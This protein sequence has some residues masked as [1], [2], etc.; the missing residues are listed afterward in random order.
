MTPE[1]VCKYCGKQYKQEQAFLN[2]TCREQQRLFETKTPIGQ[3]A[4]LCYEM[5]TIDR[6]RVPPT[7]ELFMTSRFYSSFVEFARFTKRV[8]LPRIDLFIKLMVNK[9]YP[10]TL[11]RL[12][13]VYLDYLMYLDYQLT[14]L[15]Q[16]TY[17][18]STIDD[19][20]YQM[21]VDTSKFFDYITVDEIID[22]VRARRLTPWFLF[23][24]D[25]FKA[26]LLSNQ[27]TND[28]QTILE[29]LIQPAY[30]AEKMK[31]DPSTVH[32]VKDIAKSLGL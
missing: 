15:E 12:D 3:L 28:Q 6:R 18:V 20:S 10:P 31:A 11:W 25:R 7:L 27:M 13:D 24:S 4:F 8:Q 30:W 1:L 2:H 19:I 26:L 32:Q 29:A 16:V 17:S 21:G 5:W 22:L 9:Q 14:P 23:G